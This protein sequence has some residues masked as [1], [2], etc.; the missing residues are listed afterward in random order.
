M[1]QQS[2]AVLPPPSTMTRLLIEV[3]WPNETLD[4]QS[5]PMWMFLPASL[6]PGMSSSRPRGAPEPTKIA[7]KFSDSSFF[8][9]SMRVPPL[10]SMPR[11]RM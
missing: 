3:M 1:R 4:S 7:S 9:L 5:M 6:R 11:L 8:M 10:N 2:I